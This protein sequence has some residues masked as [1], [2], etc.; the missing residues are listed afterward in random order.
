MPDVLHDLLCNFKTLWKS[1]KDAQLYLNC[2]AG[3][4]R[5]TFHINLSSSPP[6]PPKQRQPRKP[7]PARLRRRARR[8]EARARV[9]A[10][11]AANSA[12][13]DANAAENPILMARSDS[14]DTAVQGDKLPATENLN[15]PAEKAGHLSPAAVV[16]QDVERE[17]AVEADLTTTGG[18]NVDASPW[19]NCDTIEVQDIFCPDHQYL[20]QLLTPQAPRNQ[21]SFC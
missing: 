14:S 6:S 2:H 4:A 13:S 15:E 20:R 16:A 5:I 21:C 18:L 9:A 12:I 19:P 1:G 8:E 11:N 10:E 7:G 3:Q 17:D